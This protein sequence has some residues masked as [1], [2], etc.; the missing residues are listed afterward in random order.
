MT[1]ALQMVGIE[2][3]TEM[4][5]TGYLNAASMPDTVVILGDISSRQS[6]QKLLDIDFDVMF[7]INTNLSVQSQWSLA[8][9]AASSNKLKVFMCEKD[10]WIHLNE[11]Q[12]EL[13]D[14]FNARY[15]T[16]HTDYMSNNKQK[17]L[18]CR[19]KKCY[20]VKSET[21]YATWDTNGNGTSGLH[22]YVRRDVE[23]FA[24]KKLIPRVTEETSLKQI[25]WSSN[26]MSPEIKKMVAELYNEMQWGT[27]GWTP[28]TH[29][30]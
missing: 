3:A 25:S 22:I 13:R 6:Q 19:F 11:C 17:V 18:F 24:T 12:S 1:F 28:E 4:Q 5:A 29:E 14:A 23:E 15:A 27:S 8:W 21:S 2:V 20:V 26:D 16:M 10:I 9:L 7:S 30:V